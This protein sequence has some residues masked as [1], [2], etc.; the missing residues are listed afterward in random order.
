MKI[1]LL[2][3]LVLTRRTLIQLVIMC[4]CM[5]A[6]ICIFTET[7][8]T[9]GASFTTMLPLFYP[10]T[11]TAYD[12]SNNWQTYRLSLPLSR[13]TTSLGRYACF[14]LVVLGS[15][16][17]GAL[18]SYVMCIV[19]TALGPNVPFLAPFTFEGNPPIVIW[20]SSAL[21]ATT[22]LFIASITLPFVSK[23]GMT[24]GVRFIPVAFALILVLL[25]T[26]FSNEGPF[27][28]FVPDFLYYLTTNDSAIPLLIALATLVSVV[29]FFISMMISL[30]LYQKREL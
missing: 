19:G 12:E 1:M 7:V 14:L 4:G 10:F 15:M 20:G 26:L 16:L 23:M 24:K 9:I 17:L 28:A 3:D 29:M 30:K 25:F 22:V 13:N 2:T 11:I 18:I 27:A 21:G 8:A 6:F 5:V